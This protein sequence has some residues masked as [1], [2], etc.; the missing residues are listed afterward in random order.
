MYTLQI[1]IE[2]ALIAFQT[3]LETE[4]LN[5][6]HQKTNQVITEPQVEFKNFFT[7]CFTPFS[8]K[9]TEAEGPYKDLIR[10]TQVLRTNLEERVN[11]RRRELETGLNVATRSRIRM[12][13]PALEKTLLAACKMTQSFYPEKIFSR[14]LSEEEVQNFWESR[15][16]E[17]SDFMNLTILLMSEVFCQDFLT[18]LEDS[19]VCFNLE[20]WSDKN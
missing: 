13:K 16:L 8:G 1:S 14:M 19:D 15:S 4:E 18:P 5:I 9:L 20:V 6:F 2:Q 7:A 11:R 10:E 12:R 3:R 17:V